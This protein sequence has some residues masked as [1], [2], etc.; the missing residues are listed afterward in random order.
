MPL[1]SNKSR[2]Y[3]DVRHRNSL[4]LASGTTVFQGAAVGI[5]ASTGRARP[6][7]AGD[8]FAGFAEAG[9]TS[10]RDVTGATPTSVALLTHGQAQLPVATVNAINVGDSVFASDDDTFALTGSTLVG[11]I[12]RVPAAGQAVVA[13][14]GGLKRLSAAEVLATQLQITS[15]VTWATRP[16]SPYLYQP[17]F[18]TD[19][20][21]NGVHLQWNGTRWKVLFPTL[22]GE[23][24]NILTGVAQQADQYLGG[25]GPY[26][27]GFI[28]AGDILVYHFGLAKN[29]VTDTYGT[30]GTSIRLGAGGVIGDSAILQANL[31]STITATVDGGCGF[32]KWIR[33][34][35]NTTTRGLGANSA[36]PSWNGL[37]TTSA[38]PDVT[39]TIINISTTPWF[40]GLST[41][42]T[43]VPT[44]ATV[45]DAP[46]LTYQRLTL[47]P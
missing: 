25:L 42:M 13:F 28:Q 36:A 26:P 46:L 5:D 39:A 8:L 35:S 23:N 22:I 43:G 2:S 31:S 27:A 1:T 47:L 17:I 21:P 40:I 38:N 18:V 41:T 24:G 37:S 20:G 45:V 16:T 10:T 15:T 14:S 44:P 19:I 6:V 7:V 34:Q 3:T 33:V 12:V 4:Q 29:G 32:E 11:E 9:A 30:G